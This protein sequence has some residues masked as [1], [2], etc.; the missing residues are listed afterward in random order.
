VILLYVIRRLKTVRILVLFFMSLVFSLKADHYFGGY[1]IYEH[2]SGF[3]YKVTM[4]TYTDKHEFSSDKD[5]VQI[6]WGDGTKEFIHRV[7]NVGNGETI[8]PTM[9]KNIYEAIHEYS[10]TGNYQLV[11]VDDDRQKGVKNIEP[12][13]SGETLLYIDAIIPIQD[14]AVFCKNNSPLFLT[15]PYRDVHP[16]EDF[17]LTLTHYDLD[18]DSLVFKLIKPKNINAY[19]VPG[20]FFP[21]DVSIDSI[22]G[23]FSWENTPS[24]QRQQRYVFAYEIEEYR[25]GQLIG[26]S[27]SEF[28]VFFDPDTETKGDF[29]Q[30]LGPLQNNHY[31]FNGPEVIDLTVEYE[32]PDADSVFLEVFTGLDYNP[33]FRLT[34]YSSSN[35]TKAFD[36][37]E[38]NYFGQ[39]NSEGNHIITFRAGNVFGSDTLFDYHSVSVSTVSD[40]SW[41][42]SIPQNIKEVIEIAPT[43]EVYTIMPNL[44]TESVWV[45]LGNDFEDVILEVFDMRGRVVAKVENSEVNTVKLELESLRP[46]MYFFRFMRK[47]KLISVLKSVKK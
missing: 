35:G 23:L 25:E 17:N 19:P 47:G 32:N 28:S 10:D 7:N 15:E 33:H 44:F 26:L 37:L 6:I 29:S 45:N 39:D 27:V 8:N 4:V 14:S 3:T 22:T 1:I 40:T 31:R 16:G 24:I 5:S 34:N 21:D 42:C 20:Y 11:F 46:G 36:T 41:P 30:V 13:K 2:L 38:V 43:V 12:G 9:K 18:G